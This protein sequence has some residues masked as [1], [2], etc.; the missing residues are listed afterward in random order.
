MVFTPYPNKPVKEILPCGNT[1]HFVSVVWNRLNYAVLYYDID[2][3]TVT[4]FDGLNQKI[5]KWQDHI[6]HTERRAM[7]C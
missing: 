4:V 7:A 5:S 1:T 2:E 3:C 6:I